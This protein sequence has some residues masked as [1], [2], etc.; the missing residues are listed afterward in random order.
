MLSKILG[1]L[2]LLVAIILILNLLD[3]NNTWFPNKIILV[4][5]IYLLIKGLL[6]VFFLDFASTLDVI[7]GIIIL[8]WIIL[9]IPSVVILLITVFLFQKAFFSIL[10]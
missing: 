3:K 10:S 8:L 6:F 4:A 2:D 5:G 7:S 9:N 1:I